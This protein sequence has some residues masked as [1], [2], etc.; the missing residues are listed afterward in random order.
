MKTSFFDGNV[1]VLE[2]FSA[3]FDKPLGHYMQSWVPP[4][5]GNLNA[6]APSVDFY[7]C[8]RLSDGKEF[9]GT[10]DECDVFFSKD[11]NK[12]AA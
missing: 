8:V 4:S 6:H 12:D 7:K 5:S 1:F 2:N 10:R 11:F 3:N 9:E